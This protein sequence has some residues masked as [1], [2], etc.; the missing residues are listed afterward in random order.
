MNKFPGLKQWCIEAMKLGY[1]H[2]L[3]GDGTKTSL[4][5]V[6]DGKVKTPRAPANCFWAGN[7]AGNGFQVRLYSNNQKKHIGYYEFIND[8]PKP[9]YEMV[10]GEGAAQYTFAPANEEQLALF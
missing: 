2:I 3:A 5:D 4:Q 8:N 7:D 9:A 10:A 1:T 6:A